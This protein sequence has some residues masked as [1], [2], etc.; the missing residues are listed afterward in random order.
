[1]WMSDWRQKVR[2][3]SSSS[4]LSPA[5]RCVCLGNV[6]NYCV[7]LDVPKTI[8][9]LWCTAWLPAKPKSYSAGSHSQER[10]EWLGFQLEYW[11]DLSLSLSLSLSTE[12][13]TYTYTERKFLSSEKV[14]LFRKMTKREYMVCVSCDLLF[15]FL[16]LLSG[17][18]E[19]ERP[20][21]LHH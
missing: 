14:E 21:S 7:F 13:F 17:Y 2:K 18:F 10:T 9:R 4:N 8:S 16:F 3:E 11:L 6:N 1:M 15:K 12:N 20:Q 19:A 5:K